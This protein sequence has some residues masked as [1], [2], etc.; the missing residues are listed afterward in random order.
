MVKGLEHKS[1]EEW[2]RELWMFSLEKNRLR[3]DL[4]VLY[5][6]LK[7]DFSELW[8]GLFSPVTS[9]RTRGN[10]LRSY[11]GRFRLDIREKSLY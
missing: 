9:N 2:L 11:K 4:I 1:G 7:G 8:V 5:N 10:G 3:A 6:C